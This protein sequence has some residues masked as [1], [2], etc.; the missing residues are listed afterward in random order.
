MQV[1]PDDGHRRRRR[2][3]LQVPE[4]VLAGGRQGR[5]G[6]AQENVH[7][8]GLAVDRR[9]VDEQTSLIPQT[10]THQQ[11][12]RQTRIRECIALYSAN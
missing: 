7:P 1:H 12:L 5:P 9:A 8:P 4:L 10:Q 6:D 11:H 3:S 2:L